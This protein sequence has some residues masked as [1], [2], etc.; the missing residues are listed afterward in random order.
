MNIAEDTNDARAAETYRSARSRR[1][2]ANIKQLA[3]EI[4]ER[5]MEDG[6]SVGEIH[7][8]SNLNHQHVRVKHLVLLKKLGSSGPGWLI[9]VRFPRL[10]PH[11]YI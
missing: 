9:R 2:Q 10:Q 6:V 1:I 4:G 5:V 8:A 3:V 11:D 7:H